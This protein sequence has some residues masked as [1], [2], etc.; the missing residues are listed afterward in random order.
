MALSFPCNPT[1]NQTY[2][3]T[4]RLFVI[5]PTGTPVSEFEPE[6]ATRAIFVL[7]PEAKGHTRINRADLEKLLGGRDI[8]FHQDLQQWSKFIAHTRSPVPGM[9]PNL[10]AQLIHP[11][12]AR[13][14]YGHN[15][16][17]VEIDIM[18]LPSEDFARILQ[19]RELNEKQRVVQASVSSSRVYN[20]IRA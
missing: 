20:P 1:L 5:R 10:D 8:E 2:S 6:G 17:V 13:T 19:Q 11:E 12:I 18:Q 15:G 4:S 9:S 16:H 3:T 7:P 14:T